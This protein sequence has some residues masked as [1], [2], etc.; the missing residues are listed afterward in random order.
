MKE[1][2]WNKDFHSRTELYGANVIDSRNVILVE[3]R[4]KYISTYSGQVA[5]L[6][7]ASLLVRISSNVKFNID[8]VKIV[9]PLPNEGD[10]LESYI[11]DRA[12]FANPYGQFSIS[13][14]DSPYINFTVGPNG[15]GI[16]VHG[17]GWYGYTGS[18]DS[19]VKTTNECNPFGP[20]FASIHA[21]AHL[22]SNQA[23]KPVPSFLCDTLYWK[24]RE[25]TI[26]LPKLKKAESLGEIWVVGTGSVGTAAL[27]FLTLFNRNF[28]PILIDHDFVKIHNIGRSPIFNS[29]H[30]TVPKVDATKNYILEAG[31]ENIL[32]DQKA[33]HKSQFFKSRIPGKPDIVISAANEFNIRDQLE[34]S[35]PPIQIYGTTGRNWQASLFRHIPLLEACSCC[36]FPPTEYIQTE[37]AVGKVRIA[38]N[39][40]EVDASLPFLS[41]AAG[42]MTAAE[43]LKLNLEGFPF[44]RNQT[45]YYSQSKPHFFSLSIPVRSDCK[46]T[47]R[48]KAF[49][50][51]INQDSKY[52]SLSCPA[53]VWRD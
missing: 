10:D 38:E 44:S 15:T 11:L 31:V 47:L 49:T 42:L 50:K 28:R 36:R 35:Y 19:P 5:L 30:I 14:P 21:C 20:A 1:K 26:A 51:T 9:E 29:S 22:F 3:A 17:D 27:F 34:N 6:T 18:G 37:C 7:L 43:I 41:Y 8:R 12:R 25:N 48:D 13:K 24:E 39:M 23:E 32:T 52:F 46:C 16:K 33:L 53:K 40:K 4:G 2:D 45:V